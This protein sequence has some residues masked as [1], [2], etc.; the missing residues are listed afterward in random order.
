[1]AVNLPSRRLTIAAVSTKTPRAG[2]G[3]PSEELVRRI[4]RRLALGRPIPTRP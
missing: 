3:N 1:M 4:A 2:D